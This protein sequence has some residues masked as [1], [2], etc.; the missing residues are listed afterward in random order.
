MAC[1][2]GPSASTRQVPGLSPGHGGG[3]VRTF[4][5]HPPFLPPSGDSFFCTFPTKAAVRLGLWYRIV[6]FGT[7]LKEI[8]G[9]LALNGE[10][11]NNPAPI[12]CT[13]TFHLSGCQVQ[14]RISLIHNCCVPNGDHKNLD[15]IMSLPILCKHISYISW[16]YLQTT[17]PITVQDILYYCISLNM[18]S[19]FP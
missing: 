8:H 2:W 6:T 9:T 16:L 12:S 13:H 14:P 1:S 18:A 15:H 19:N 3:A 17:L 7:F 5:L 4:F 10:K 11:R